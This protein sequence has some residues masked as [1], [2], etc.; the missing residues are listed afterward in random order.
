MEKL[1]ILAFM[2][3]SVLSNEDLGQIKLA[4]MQ[5]LLAKSED[6]VVHL[7]P[8]DYNTLVE[9]NPRPYDVVTMFTVKSGCT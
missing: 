9:E 1:F 4:K 8:K 7:P 5:K 3:I 2:I 6:G